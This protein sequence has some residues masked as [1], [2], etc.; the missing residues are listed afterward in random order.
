MRV[1]ERA[2]GDEGWMS[3]EDDLQ[4][5]RLVV[6]CL[7]GRLITTGY[8][9]RLAVVRRTSL[10]GCLDDNENKEISLHDRTDIFRIVNDCAAIYHTP[11]TD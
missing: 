8:I 5:L 6:I 1:Y 7:S 2:K 3:V 9:A 11:A 4:N 10:V